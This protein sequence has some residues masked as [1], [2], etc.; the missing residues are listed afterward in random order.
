MRFLFSTAAALVLAAAI[1]AETVTYQAVPRGSMMKIDGTSTIHDWTVECQVIG[2]RM[3]LD[4]NFPLDPSKEAPKD[5]KVTPKVKVIIPVRQLKSGTSPMDTVMHNAMNVESHPSI[6]YS[7]IEMT[8][9]GKADNGQKFATKGTIT[10]NGVTRT[11]EFDVVMTKV[12][13]KKLKVSGETKVKM[14]DFNIQPPAPK[15]ALGAIKTGDDVKLTFEWLTQ[16][17]AAA[18]E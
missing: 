16:Q 18:K 4:S 13:E 9:K 17:K 11:N 5:L 8:P 10:C 12:D 15:I 1:H 7:L 3:E 2:G 14:T 6:E